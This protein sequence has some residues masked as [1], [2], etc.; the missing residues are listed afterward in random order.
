MKG[1]L[2]RLRG[3]IGTGLTWALGWAGLFGAAGT[4]F[5]AYS[6]PRL[7]FVGGFMGLVVG[8]AFAVTLTIAERRHTLEDLSLW[9]T[10]IWGGLGGFLVAVVFSGSGGLIWSLATTTALLGTVSS[11]GTVAVAKRA[12]RRLI[13]GEEEPILSLGGGTADGEGDLDGG[14]RS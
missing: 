13:E 1:S 7:A 3:I 6:I 2:K 8:G 10:A 12:N 9:R 4:I 5:G 11:A 14:G